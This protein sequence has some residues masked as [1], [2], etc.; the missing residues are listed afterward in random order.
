MGRW[1]YSHSL[2]ML[3]LA[4][5]ISGE[6][7]AQTRYNCRLPDGRAYTSDKACANQGMVYYGPQPDRNTQPSYIPKVGEAPEYLKYM[8][9][10]C[11]SMHDAIRTSAVRGVKYEVTAETSKNYQ[12]ECSEDEQQARSRYSQ[13]RGDKQ[14]VKQDIK[15]EQELNVSNTKINEQQC[16]ES[17]RIL[18][19]KRARTDLNDGEKNDLKRFEENYKARCGG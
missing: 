9:P 18:Y 16:G 1:K 2:W 19:A 11:S 15:R 7:Y 4:I 3:F 5:F 12:R 17:K 6:I 10:K 8:S 13:D 14:K